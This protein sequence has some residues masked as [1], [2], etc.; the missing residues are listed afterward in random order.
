MPNSTA[1]LAC[2]LEDGFLSATRLLFIE[3]ATP[4]GS[5]LKPKLGN[6]PDLLIATLCRC[7][8]YAGSG[9]SGT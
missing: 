6:T 9:G 2:L 3:T 1:P 8:V 5:D 4:A 7:Q